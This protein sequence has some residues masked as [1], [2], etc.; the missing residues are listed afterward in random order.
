MRYTKRMKKPA[1]SIIL[2]GIKHCGKSTQAKLV[3]SAIGATVYDTDDLIYDQTGLD[4]RA[5]YKSQ[6]KDAFMQAELRACE[7]LRDI[8]TEGSQAQD[9]AASSDE[10][11][12]QD[13][14]SPP[15]KKLAVIATGGGIC[16]N[17]P[18][19]QILKALGSIVY[20]EIDEKS[21][22]DRIIREARFLPNGRI[23]NLP[24]Y[25]AAK[26]PR[27]EKE[28]RAIFHDFY[29]ERTKKY[30]SLADITVQ[31]QGSRSENTKKI[32]SALELL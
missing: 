14:K 25:I 15:A 11:S 18:A 24:A 20:L 19:M 9:A 29:E 16:Q 31:A 27:D 12:L 8:L 26:N 5:I 2:C 7:H 3:A 32:L 17:E 13:Q 30:R 10:N 4:T 1:R 22:A 21:A 28:A 23:E 6:G